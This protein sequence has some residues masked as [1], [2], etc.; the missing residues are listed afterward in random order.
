[1]GSYDEAAPDNALTDLL[2]D[3]RRFEDAHGLDFG[4]RDR[5]AHDHYLGELV[6]TRARQENRKSLACKEAAETPSKVTER[7]AS[8]WITAEL[9]PLMC[10]ATWA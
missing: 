6:R 9:A 1:M 4:D 7:V 3:A 2:A 10:P 8:S 5:A